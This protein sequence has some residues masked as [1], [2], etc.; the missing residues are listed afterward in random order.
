[1]MLE[2]FA[3]L[4]TAIGTLLLVILTSVLNQIKEVKEEIKILQ[5]LDGRIKVLESQMQHFDGCKNFVKG[6]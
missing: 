3:I 6:N 5:N 4:I 2:I 1:M